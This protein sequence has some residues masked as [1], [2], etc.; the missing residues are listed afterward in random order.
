MLIG[1]DDT[2]SLEGMCTTY[3]AALLA[4]KLGTTNYPRLIRLNPNIPWKTRGNGA[5]ALEVEENSDKIKEIVLDY[6]KK[7]ARINDKNTNPGVVFLEKLNKKKGE[8]LIKFYK[9]TVSEL[10]KIEEAENIAKLVGAEIHRFNNGRGIIGALA[11]VGAEL[12]DKTYELIVYRKKKNYGK[13]RR[14]DENSLLEM[15]KETYPETFDNIDLETGR[16]LIT[17]RGYDPIFLGIRGENPETLKKAWKMIKLLEEIERMQI[18]ETNQGTD[19]HLRNKKISELKA[20]DCAIL[21]GYVSR[22]PS[23]IEG[24]H[25]LF[26]ISDST[27]E[28]DCA[29]YR[30]TGNFRNIIKGLVVGDKVIVY[31]GLGKYH[32]TLN[33]EKIRILK[34]KRLFKKENPVCCDKRMTSAGGGKGFKCRKC[35]KRLSNIFKIIKEIPRNIKL[36]FY[37]VP[38]RARRHLSMPLIRMTEGGI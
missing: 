30:Q 16:I 4:E 3:L 1:I 31:G 26:S 17:P 22:N 19:A 7:Y 8:I 36:G 23:I 6:V 18:F 29:A 34:L 14:I 37:E 24:G 35:G 20:Y 2:D 5:V 9:K 32:N 33:L 27:G 11:A 12:S 21:R 28:I 15:D 38:P 13:K 10:V 25:T